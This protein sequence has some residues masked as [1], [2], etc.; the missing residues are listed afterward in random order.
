MNLGAVS[1]LPFKPVTGTWYRAIPPQHLET[2]L[3]YRHTRTKPSRY[4]PGRLA[5]EA[6][7]TIYLSESPI[8]AMLEVGAILGSSSNVNELLPNPA[9]DYT[10]LNIQVQ[11]RN[12]L[13]L[14]DVEGTHEPLAS[15][16]QELTGDWVAYGRRTASH[17]VPGPCG[18]APTQELGEAM[19]AA[20]KFA[21]FLT[22]SAK[23]PYQRVLGV[24]PDR[25]APDDFIRYVY[26][27]ATGQK[28]FNVP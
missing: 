8:L 12:V 27:D 23:F 19:H 2:A 28:T 15:N 4:N 20:E 26:S 21:G 7:D 24:F 13:D 18:V 10:I 17:S 25:I 9:A 6:F 1:G 5:R 3:Q 14:T 11:L 16:A 22:I